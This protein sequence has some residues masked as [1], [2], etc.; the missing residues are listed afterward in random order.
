MLFLLTAVLTS[1]PLALEASVP[2]HREG[3]A[4][5]LLP[6]SQEA[7]FSLL[8]T[9]FDGQS[10]DHGGSTRYLVEFFGGAGLGACR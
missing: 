9:N 8:A 2:A 4:F 7:K 3:G 1:H 6:N 10:G 5:L